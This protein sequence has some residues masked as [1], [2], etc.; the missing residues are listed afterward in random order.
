MPTFQLPDESKMRPVM[1]PEFQTRSMTNRIYLVTVLTNTP[2]ILGLN[3]P[4][5]HSSI[6]WMFRADSG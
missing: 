1:P 2:T 3:G 5:L 6:A 4:T